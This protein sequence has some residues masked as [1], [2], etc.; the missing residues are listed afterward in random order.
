MPV[1]SISEAARLS[2]VAR[3]TLYRKHEQGKITFSALADGQ[4]GIDTA[5]LYRVYPQQSLQDSANTIAATATTRDTAAS[6]RKIAELQLELRLTREQLTAAAQRETWLQRQVENL[7]ESLKLLEHRPVDQ[8]QPDQ[9][10]L[11]QV[12]D[13]QKALDLLSTQQVAQEQSPR[14][15]WARLFRR[16]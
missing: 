15:F 1:V 14:G 3:S 9:E 6:E 4:P 13:L 5:E 12:D 10:L 16:G 11:K 7:T 8:P 2:G